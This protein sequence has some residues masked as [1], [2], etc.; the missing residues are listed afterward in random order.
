[1]NTVTVDGNKTDVMNAVLW[2]QDQFGFNGFEM[3]NLFPSWDWRFKFKKSQDAV[4]FAL[5]WS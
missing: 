4:L 1:M 2:C 5:K 3:D